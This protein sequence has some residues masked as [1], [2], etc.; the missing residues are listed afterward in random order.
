MSETIDV[1]K[2]LDKLT[3]DE[4]KLMEAMRADDDGAIPLD[5]GV[6][7]TLSRT[8]AKDEPAAGVDPQIEIEDPVEPQQ[9]N[10]TVPH[11]AFHAER[12]R[13]KA[14]EARAAEVEREKAA[15]MARLQ[16][17]LNTVIGIA[18]V[19]ATPP[20]AAPVA[21]EALPDVNT[22]PVGHFRA[23]S[24]RQAKKLGD[25]EAILSGF[26][27]RQQSAAQ[28]QELRNW[29]AAQEAAFASTEPS[30]N[31]AMNHL[32]ASRHE[33]LAA[34]G[35]TDPA[36]RQRII[37][38]DVTNIA[39]R[40]RQEGANFAERLFTLAVK[41]GFE[42][43]APTAAATPA[44]PALDAEPAVDRTASARDNATTIGSLGAA[45]PT[46]LSVAKIADM[47]EAQFAALT[48]RLRKEPGALER[49]MGE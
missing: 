34:I 13:R 49:L 14:A 3:P 31:A 11:Q 9:Q 36:E 16:E 21:E 43:A 42:K 26:Q 45:P 1:P 15:D 25:L 19:A 7:K 40:A 5:D 37:A 35:V 20:A 12:E 39:N 48:E 17:R 30:Y 33:E 32:T 47:N 46:R 29:G 2:G 6:K 22:D 38:Q 24:E 10:N 4:V 44:I 8:A 23:V 27:Q 41:R 28:H 18:Q